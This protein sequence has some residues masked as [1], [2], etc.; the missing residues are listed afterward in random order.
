VMCGIHGAKNLVSVLMVYATALCCGWL[1]TV[2]FLFL[3]KTWCVI[4]IQECYVMIIE[5]VGCCV[6]TEV[7]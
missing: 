3:V 2:I 4:R 1:L 7:E 6:V 5:C